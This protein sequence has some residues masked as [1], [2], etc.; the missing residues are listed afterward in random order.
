MATSHE[1]VELVGDRTVEHFARAVLLAAL[2][3]GLAQLS[4]PYPF[5]AAPISFQMV[6]AYLAGLWLGPLWGGFSMGLYLTVGALGQPVFSGGGAGLGYATGPTGGFL[7]GFVLAA[8]LI[9]A[10]VHRSIEPRDLSTIGMTR[11]TVA[12]F[13]GLAVIYLVGAPWLGYS[14]GWTVWETLVG[15]AVVFV[16]GDVVKIASTVAL[17]KSSGL[18]TLSE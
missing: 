10:L 17:V 7:V 2:T 14:L 1:T 11:M 9:G 15:G 4:I 12:L 16:P 3:A 5:S 8:V 18:D 6:G 13:A